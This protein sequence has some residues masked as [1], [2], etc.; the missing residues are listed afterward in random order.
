MEGHQS[1]HMR[2]QLTNEFF[3]KQNRAIKTFA[4]NLIK[5]IWKY[6]SA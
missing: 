5:L 2:A 6:Y 3:F 1:L 4:L